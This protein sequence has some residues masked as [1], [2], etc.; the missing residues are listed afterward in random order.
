MM[1]N[2]AWRNG[3]E[4]LFFDLDPGPVADDLGAVLIASMRR[5]SSRTDENFGAPPGW[6]QVIRTSRRSSPGAG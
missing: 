3:A 4:T 6:S 5:M 1:S 2:S